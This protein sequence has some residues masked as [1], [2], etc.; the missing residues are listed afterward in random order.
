MQKDRRKA[1]AKGE[2]NFAIGYMMYKVYTYE[3][4]QQ[5]EMLYNCAEGIETKVWHVTI[6]NTYFFK[7][8][9]IKSFKLKTIIIWCFKKSLICLHCSGE[10]SLLQLDDPDVGTLDYRYF[11]SHQSDARSPNYINLREVSC[12]DLTFLVVKHISNGIISGSKI[13]PVRT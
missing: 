12:K 13:T 5:F 10:C 7:S 11:A 3:Y 9:K 8:D 4:G 1:R 2:D 6:E